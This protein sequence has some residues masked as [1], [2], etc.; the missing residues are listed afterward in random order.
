MN[1]RIRELMIQSNPQGDF[2]DSEWLFERFAQ[3]IVQE[4]CVALHP[5]LRDMIS[6]DQCVH[7]IEKHFG[8]R[9]INERI[10]KMAVQSGFPVRTASNDFT[11]LY[12]QLEK[13]VELIVRECAETIQ[14]QDT[15][16]SLKSRTSWAIKEHFGVER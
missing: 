1:E 11:D 7:L 3:L 5:M 16:T 8:D 4:C 2:E 9:R 14:A 13:F 6:R 10:E 12:P 15:G